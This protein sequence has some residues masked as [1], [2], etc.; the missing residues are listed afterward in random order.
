VSIKCEADCFP[1]MFPDSD[2]E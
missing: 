1:V 2:R